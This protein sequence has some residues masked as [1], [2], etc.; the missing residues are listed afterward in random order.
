MTKNPWEN[1]NN[2]EDHYITYMLYR[3]GKSVEAIS[4]IRGKTKNEVER[5]ILK[6]KIDLMD[7]R[8]TE[9]E[10]VKI[11]SLS[12]SE[13]IDYLGGL[14]DLE[15]E[16]LEEEIYKRYIKFK[17][18]EDRIILIWLIGELKSKKLLPF[19]KMEL[20][21]N[22]VNY[23]RLSCS[24][25]GKIGDVSTKQWLEEMVK[26]ENPQVRQ[27]AIKAL[28][29]IGDD[30]TVLILKGAYENE[31]VMYVKRGIRETI[32]EIEKN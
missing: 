8:K 28:S 19:L 13:R 21:S 3:E 11:I 32:E 16:K 22:K 15:K 25:L 5:E 10:L 6:S 12:K 7:Y 18:P 9:D 1:L 27:Y 2:I 26:D 29:H 31:K 24:A 4:I 23:R 14:T 30:K 17:N 20:K